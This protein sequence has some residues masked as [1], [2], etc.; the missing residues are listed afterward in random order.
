M[1]VKMKVFLLLYIIISSVG[2][3][4]T[5]QLIRPVSS[6][7]SLFKFKFDWTEPTIEV[8]KE[9]FALLQKDKDFQFMIG[10]MN[11]EAYKNLKW[12]ESEYLAALIKN[13]TN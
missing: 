6:S 11:R 7:H 9:S 8:I 5:Y 3:L 4:R 1:A 12:D 13:G 2:F 10:A